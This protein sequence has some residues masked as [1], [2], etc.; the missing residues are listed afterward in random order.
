MKKILVILILVC[1]TITFACAEDVDLSGMSFDQLVALKDRINLAIWNSSEWQEVTVPQG[2]WIV[3]E[4]IPAGK[5]TVRCADLGR[6]DYLMKSCEISWG[7]DYDKSK[8]SIPI[9]M[10]LGKKEIYNPNSSDYK[11][12]QVTEVTI[13]LEDGNV[14]VIHDMY[15][16]AVFSPYAGKPDLGF[17]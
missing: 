5:W 7:T 1:M 2:V 9:K 14:V 17:K 16:K 10:R 13:D 8:N 4:D 3:G 6:Y 12:G 11:P 15:N